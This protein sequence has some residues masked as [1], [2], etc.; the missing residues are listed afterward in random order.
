M[1]HHPI[2]SAISSSIANGL[3]PATPPYP[4]ARTHSTELLFCVAEKQAAITET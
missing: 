2:F 3:N 1:T 4:E